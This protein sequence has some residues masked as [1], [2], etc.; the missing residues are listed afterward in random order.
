MSVTAVTNLDQFKAAVTSSSAFGVVVSYWA[1]WCPP[2]L[3]V[4]EYLT[5]ASQG[6]SVVTVDVDTAADVCELNGVENVPFVAFYRRK[7]DGTQSLVADVAGAKLAVIE[8]DLKSLSIADTR[9]NFQSVDDY[10]KHLLNVDKVVIFIT[11]TPSHPVCGFTK[12]LVALFAEKKVPYTYV[13]IMAD[14]E[15]C[16]RLKS[17]SNWPT[18][19]QIYADGS[20]VGGLDIV[21]ELEKEGEFDSTFGV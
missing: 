18:Y 19:P 16:D 3:E 8:R 14:N 15:L 1:S 11:G 6:A 12:K 21:L 17:Y 13:D 4:N 7:P 20:L 9:N 10:I 2:S 5:K